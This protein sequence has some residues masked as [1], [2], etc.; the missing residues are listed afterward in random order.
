MAQHEDESR[1]ET[2]GGSADVVAG[3]VAIHQ[4]HAR[5][6]RAHEVQIKQGGALRVKAEDVE[7]TQGGIGFAST[8][9]ARVTAGGVGVL[10]ASGPVELKATAAQLVLVRDEAELGQ[11]AA[12]VVAARS[13]EISDSAVGVLIARRVEGRNVRVLFGVP[14]AI[15]FGAAA[16]AMLWLLGRWRR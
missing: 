14:A 2:A 8:G 1:E 10:A 5:S 12:G 15:A 16:G 7:I 4:G 11:S 3:T 9:S 6:V 13:V